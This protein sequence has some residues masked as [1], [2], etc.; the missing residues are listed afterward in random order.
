MSRGIGDIKLKP[1]VSAEPEII[2]KEIEDQDLFIVLA[3]D[4]L[5]DVMQNDEV[6]RFVT[7]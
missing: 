7:R 5:W 4:G 2:E 6:G 1:Y 3:T